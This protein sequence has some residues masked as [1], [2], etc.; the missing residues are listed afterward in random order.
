[1]RSANEASNS[2]H[3]VASYKLYDSILNARGY[4]FD[5][6]TPYL[7]HEWDLEAGGPIIKDRTFFYGQ[8]FAQRIPLGTPNNANVP[9][10]LWRQG[11]FTNTIIDPQ[12]GQPFPNNTI[13]ANRISPVALAFQNKYYPVPTGANANLLPINNNYSFT[14]P[15]NSDLYRGD[16]LSGRVDHNLTQK[17][18]LFGRWLMRRTPYVLTNGL[19][20]LFW[21]R[22][23][24]HQQWAAGDTHVFSPQLLNTFKFGLAFDYIVDGQTEAGRTPPNG[25]DVLAQTG[26][27]GS[28]PSGLTGAGFPQINI[29]GL[30]PLSGVAGGVKSDNRIV[31]AS[32]SIDWQVGRHVW[33]FGFNTQHY[34]IYRGTNP[35]YGT[36]SFDGSL[37]APKG[38]KTPD[39]VYA[40]FL[41]GLPQQS[42]RSNPLVNRTM[43]VSEWG[44]FA[45]D[46]YKVNPKLTLNYGAR[47]DYYGAPTASD[48]LMYNW[49]PNTNTVLVDPKAISKVSPLYP[50][51]SSTNPLG[52]KV[53]PG[54]VTAIPG[55]SNF[56]PR[57]GAAYRLTDHFVVRGGYGIY[58]SRI[59]GSYG[60]GNS[61]GFAN[62][63]V[64]NYFSL[65]N[66]Q[67]GSTGPFSITENYLNTVT[68][69]QP[70]LQFPNPYPPSTGSATVPSQS[71]NGY[72]RESGNGHIHQFSVSVER[73]IASFGLRASY[74]GS[75]STGQNYQIN[76]NKPH[77]SITPFDASMRPFQPFVKTTYMRYD[78]SAKYDGLQLEVKRRAGSIL[79]D[80]NYTYARSIANYLD[81]ENPYDV[82]S[83]WAN[84]GPTRHHYASISATW[85]LPF[86][87]GQRYLSTASAPIQQIAGNWSLNS[88]TYL[89]SGYWYSPEYSGSDS[90]NTG[91]FGSLP[92][93]VGNLPDRVGDP[94]N[95]PGGRTRQHWFNTAAFAVPQI[96]HFGNALPNS[97][98]NQALYVT[99]LG[100]VKVIPITERVKFH[101]TGEISNLFNHAEF[102]PPGGDVT[103]DGGGDAFTSQVDVFSS[104]ERSGPR[105]ITFQGAFRF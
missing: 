8:W 10:Q 94:N 15:F 34:K 1:M 5:N 74:V 88:I 66:P 56:V 70:L 20:D 17:N 71:V 65:I 29:N 59:T 67:L 93:G 101:F 53:A 33:K 21:T 75:R 68:A 3:G 100:V 55:K 11:Q 80:A 97:L 86:G 92:D 95:V 9:I 40:D 104:L 83:H 81:T 96:G 35:N 82:L 24:R 98:E 50:V 89:G 58:I 64:L 22:L 63:P 54:N 27:Q 46:T 43:N 73:E 28:N 102:L 41:L 19:P 49:D 44:F 25:A 30:T 99:H 84:D 77:P 18:S 91:T 42:Q 78:G 6:K 23:R 72:P 26:L 2:F 85:A 37:S 79:L 90:S 36:L 76:T 103:P 16:W 14:F 52:I 13:P 60:D 48:H 105:Q 39:N 4:F 62:N 12:T 32:D 51:L 87:K 47:W 31:T 45:E 7:Q 69:G 61:T 38:H 57:L